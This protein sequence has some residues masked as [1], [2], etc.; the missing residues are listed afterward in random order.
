MVA[1][2]ASRLTKLQ[3]PPVP[4]PGSQSPN[5]RASVCTQKKVNIVQSKGRESPRLP[6]GAPCMSCSPVPSQCGEASP[7]ARGAGPNRS[8]ADPCVWTGTPIPLPTD[9]HCTWSREPLHPQR[10]TLPAAPCHPSPARGRAGSGDNPATN[11]KQVRRR[12]SPPRRVQP[13]SPPQ[14]EAQAGVS[15]GGGD[16]GCQHPSSNNGSFPPPGQRSWGGGRQ[17]PSMHPQIS[18]PLPTRQCQAGALQS[19]VGFVG[20][21]GGRRRGQG[22]AAPPGPG[23]ATGRQPILRIECRATVQQP[24]SSELML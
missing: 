2:P 4:L 13:H 11:K 23:L 1:S 20:A 18:R 10:S 19:A 9:R 3:E 21:G 16:A 14:P 5:S 17:P 8:G 12:E 15:I 24:R 6:R 22:W 7:R